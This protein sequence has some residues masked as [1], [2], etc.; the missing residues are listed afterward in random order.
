MMMSSA[1]TLKDYLIA[2]GASL[3]VMR[4]R[5]GVWARKPHRDHIEW[6]VLTVRNGQKRPA[7]TI[8]T[9]SI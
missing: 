5:S 6:V 2:Q 3:A 1:M 7:T 9:H 4:R 8:T